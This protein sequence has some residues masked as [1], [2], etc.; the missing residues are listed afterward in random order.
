V[1]ERQEKDERRRQIE[2]AVAGLPLKPDAPVDFVVEML[3]QML[4]QAD[5][6]VDA[7]MVARPS[8]AKTLRNLSTAW[9]GLQCAIADLDR[10]ALV[11]LNEEKHRRGIT[12]PPPH[13]IWTQASELQA[14]LDR[15]EKLPEIAQEAAMTVG[16][17]KRKP[18]Q[19]LRGLAYAAA[20]S[21]EILT[22]ETAPTGGNENPL[23]K[24]MGAIFQAGDIKAPNGADEYPDAA[25][26]ARVGAKIARDL[27]SGAKVAEISWWLHPD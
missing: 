15:F 13:T 12:W 27:A 18:D 23:H 8:L 20:K 24:F 11:A 7:S 16:Q 10:D 19:Y 17:R 6:V 2:A 5:R 3:D 1:A 4:G 25:H 21:F 26:W 9:L 14:A 22:G